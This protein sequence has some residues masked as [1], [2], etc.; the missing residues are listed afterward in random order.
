VMGMRQIC[1]GGVLW[2]NHRI[3]RE[4]GFERT[5][6]K[7]ACV[8]AHVAHPACEFRLIQR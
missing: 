7:A 5:R 1:F 3:L 2:R 6:T 8:T 4:P